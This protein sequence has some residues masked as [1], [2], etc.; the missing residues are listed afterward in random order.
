MFQTVRDTFY[1]MPD[2]VVLYPGHDYVETNLRFTLTYEPEN[3]DARKLLQEVKLLQQREEFYSGTIAI[4]R[5]MNL[6]FRCSN[7][8][9]SLLHSLE[10]QFTQGQS[11]EALQVF[12][13]LRKLRDKW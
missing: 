11:K 6:F 2:D 10:K 5:K 8:S 13:E 9:L 4:E 1:D 3:A 7:P 12:L